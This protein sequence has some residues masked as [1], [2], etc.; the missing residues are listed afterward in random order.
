MSADAG[1]VQMYVRSP[2]SSFAGASRSPTT[3]CVSDLDSHSVKPPS[4]TTSGAKLNKHSCQ[5][6]QTKV[7]RLRF[8]LYDV[9][10]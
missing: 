2:N 8:G 9:V 3:V 7:R 10:A 1:G 5:L 6:T 4:P